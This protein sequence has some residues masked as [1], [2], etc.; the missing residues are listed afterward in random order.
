MI[1][2][3]HFAF[4]L[5]LLMLV[6]KTFCVKWDSGMSN[7]SGSMFALARDDG[8]AALM[9]KATHFPISVNT[10]MCI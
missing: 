3:F 9:R 10:F 7:F 2:T 4:E 8:E 5:M 6:I 1:N